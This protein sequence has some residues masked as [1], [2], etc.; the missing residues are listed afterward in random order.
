MIFNLGV[1]FLKKLECAMFDHSMLLA[2]F[3]LP[4]DLNVTIFDHSMLLARI[5]LS[6]DL[7]IQCYWQKL[8]RPEI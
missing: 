6:G 1:V 7:I 5:V 8:Y 4:R 2:R 3:V